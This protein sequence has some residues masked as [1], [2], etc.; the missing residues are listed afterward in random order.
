MFLGLAVTLGV[1]FF[2]VPG[3]FTVILAD[4]SK[5]G[6]PMLHLGG[7]EVTGIWPNLKAYFFIPIPAVGLVVAALVSR[8]T[9]YTSDQVMVQRFQA[10]KTIRDARRGFVLAALGDVLWM[11]ILIFVGVA[12]F[13][14]F[15][16][17]GGIPVW[18][19]AENKQDQIF[20]YFMGKVFPAGLTGLVISAIFAASLCSLGSA[21]NSVTSVVMIDFYE[22]IGRRQLRSGPGATVDDPTRQVR[23]SRLITLIIGIVAVMLS[24]NVSRLGTILEIANKVINGFTGAI[25]GIFWLGMFTRRST[26]LSVFIGGVLGTLMAIYTIFWSSPDLVR[27]LGMTGLFPSG[28]PISFI[29]P[30][31][32]GL[33]TTLVVGFGA[34]LIT[35]KTT[36]GTAAAQKWSWRSVTR[37]KLIEEPPR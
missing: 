25:L 7:G 15:R 19:Q 17:Q 26:S 18:L 37:T 4:F 22:R 6:D 13:T 12:L 32:F 21:I 16:Q 31:T 34:S 23:V 1:I 27:D 8:V 35:G 5:A 10:C 14:Y 3:G 33:V 28:K 29:W 24:C 9:N 20:P 2:N 30:S 36:A 11:T